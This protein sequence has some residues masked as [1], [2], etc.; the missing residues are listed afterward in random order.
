MK[1]LPKLILISAGCWATSAHAQV[2]CHFVAGGYV[3]PQQS[4]SA[5]IV[6]TS[7][8]PLC[9]GVACYKMVSNPK[10]PINLPAAATPN[11]GVTVAQAQ[12]FMPS[13]VYLNFLNNPNIDL[14]VTSLGDVEL[15]RLSTELARNDVSG[16]TYSIMMYAAEKLSAANLHRLQAAFG[17]TVFATAL[18]YMPAATRAA[19]NASA[20]YAP[21]PLG[22]Y[23]NSLNPSL[24]A[25]APSPGDAYLYDLLLDEKTAS[26]GETTTVAVTHVSRYVNARIKVAPLVVIGLVIAGI[27]LALQIYDSP[28]MQALGNAIADDY[29]ARQ[30]TWVNGAPVVI[31]IPNLGNIVAPPIDVP[32]PT[33]PPIEGD[34]DSNGA[35]GLLL[36]M[37]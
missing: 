18:A 5:I 22:V 32:L 11:W 24:A 12:S 33:M 3:C 9:N 34:G 13:T 27:S 37:C 28:S 16:Y 4:G 36:D 21:I 31:Q 30:M 15:A 35:C 14:A 7:A 20:A 29:F 2:G 25:S 19:Y 10:I 17:P 26:A 8:I 6:P 23:W 1:L